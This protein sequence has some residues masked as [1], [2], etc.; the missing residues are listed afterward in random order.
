MRPKCLLINLVPFRDG[1]QRL[2]PYCFCAN[3]DCFFNPLN[4]FLE[5][6]LAHINKWHY[7]NSLILRLWLI[8]IASCVFFRSSFSCNVKKTRFAIDRMR[9]GLFNFDFIWRQMWHPNGASMILIRND[10]CGAPIETIEWKENEINRKNRKRTHANSLI[11]SRLHFFHAL[12]HSPLFG[13]A[14]QDKNNGDSE[15]D[16]TMIIHGINSIQNVRLMANKM[17]KWAIF[18]FA[19]FFC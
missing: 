11:I 5:T 1:R 16:T 9:V 17:M 2:F 15:T 14:W 3:F 6:Q 19:S 10:R 4:Y 18:R 8:I 13:V 12:L 7:F